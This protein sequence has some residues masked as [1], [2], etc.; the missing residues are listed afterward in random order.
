MREIVGQVGCK[1]GAMRRILH[2]RTKVQ[3]SCLTR[4]G[5]THSRAAGTMSMCNLEATAKC[6]DI[7]V[8]G[9]HPALNGA[10]VSAGASAHVAPRRASGLR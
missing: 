5:R 10:W 1:T 9:R 8:V 4:H 2:A 7:R 6:F 3:G